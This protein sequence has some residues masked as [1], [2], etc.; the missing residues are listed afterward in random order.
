MDWIDRFGDERLRDK[1]SRQGQLRGALDRA[2]EGIYHL[3][4][5]LGREYKL[6]AVLTDTGENLIRMRVK[7]KDREERDRIWDEAA[8][9]ILNVREE[10]EVDI[11]CGIYKLRS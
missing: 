4:E 9:I 10:Q 6:Q 1:A 11:L 7:Y 5:N 2:L 8:R 3:L